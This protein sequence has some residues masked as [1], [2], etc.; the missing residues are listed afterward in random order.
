MIIGLKEYNHN[1]QIRVEQPVREFYDL[2]KKDDRLIA[3]SDKLQPFGGVPE[4]IDV[5]E[6]H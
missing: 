4:W 5:T 6:L 2:V 1:G 3:E